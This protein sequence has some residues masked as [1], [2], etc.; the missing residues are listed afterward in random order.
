MSGDLDHPE[1]DPER[2]ELVAEVRDPYGVVL[3]CIDSRAAPERVFG[4]GLDDL[5]V[6]ARAGGRSAR[7]SPGPS[8]AGP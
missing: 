6:C 1:R 2:R 5:Y 4:T 8:S 3:T 7:W